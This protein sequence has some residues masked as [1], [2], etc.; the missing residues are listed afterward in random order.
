[1]HV[2]QVINIRVVVRAECRVS[3]LF[4]IFHSHG[5]GRADRHIS[6]NMPVER[7]REGWRTEDEGWRMEG[8]CDQVRWKE[9]WS[10]NRQIGDKLWAYLTA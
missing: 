7:E 1:M 8:E 10:S 4:F 6:T 9:Y 2:E 5:L 3:F